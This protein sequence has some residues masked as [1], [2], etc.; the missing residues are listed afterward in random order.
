MR[1][2]FQSSY[3]LFVYFRNSRQPSCVST[4]P[5]AQITRWL[6]QSGACGFQLEDLTKHDMIVFVR[7]KLRPLLPNKPELC[8]RLRK[9]LVKKSQG[10]FLWL[11]L[12]IQS[13]IEVIENDDPET[14]LLSRVDT[15]QDDLETLYTDMWQRVKCQQLRNSPN[16]CEIISLRLPEQVETCFI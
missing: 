14:L 13:L 11:N 3:S 6:E 12:A 15:L 8:R 2:D 16:S 10:V 4:R 9:D 5:E 7:N 1:I